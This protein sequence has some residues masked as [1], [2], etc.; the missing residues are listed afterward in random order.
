[1]SE[2]QNARIRKLFEELLECSPAERAARMNGSS[3]EDP[4]VLEEVRRLLAVHDDDDSFLEHPWLRGSQI[5]WKGVQPV[6]G[7]TGEELIRQRIGP[8]LIE[9]VVGVGGMGVVYRARQENLDRTVALKLIRPG[10]LSDAARQ[11]FDYEVAVLGRLQHPGIARIYDSGTADTGQGS[12]PYFVMEL[13]EGESLL[14]YVRGHGLDTDQRIEL[15]AK[16]CDAV[17]HAHQKGV[18][19]RDLKPTNILVDRQG[20][21]KVLDFGVARAIDSD[22]QVTSCHTL[23]GQLIGTAH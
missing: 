9:S 5:E 6:P 12:Q 1:M 3:Q 14:D 17:H 20:Q 19:H 21:P 2:S 7:N 10:C 16:I 11:R 15:L 22:L 18:I 23:L 13:V 4:E 8:Y